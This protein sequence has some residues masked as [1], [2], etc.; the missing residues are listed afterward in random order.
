MEISL[1]KLEY[2][3]TPFSL[4]VNANS[5]E[6]RFDGK[7]MYDVRKMIEAFKAYAVKFGHSEGRNSQ[8]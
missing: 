2:K 4:F 8:I 3:V 6:Y 7:I 1:D 5:K